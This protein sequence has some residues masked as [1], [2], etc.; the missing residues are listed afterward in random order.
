MYANLTN[1]DTSR[2]NQIYSLARY[3]NAPVM[4]HDSALAFVL[5]SSGIQFEAQRFLIDL[6]DESWPQVTMDFNCGPDHSRR[7]VFGFRR[8]SRE[9]LLH[10]HFL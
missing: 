2:H 6:L 10:A 8:N 5:E 7:N 4:H 9:R 1:Q 3:R